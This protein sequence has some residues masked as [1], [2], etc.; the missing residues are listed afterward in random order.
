MVNPHANTSNKE[1]DFNLFVDDD[2][3]AYHI[4]LKTWPCW[5]QPP[6]RPVPPQWAA[7]CSGLT[8]QKL[9]FDFLTAVGPPIFLNISATGATTALEAPIM[10]KAHGWY[11]ATAGTLS[12]AAGGGTDVFALRSRQPMGKYLPA[13]RA[14]PNNGCIA[15]K[16]DSR[17]QGSATFS[18]DGDLIWLGNQWLTSQAPRQERNYDLLRFAKLNISAADGLIE[19]FHWR[20]NIS[21]VV[22]AHV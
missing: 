9:S 21:V 19:P 15:Q 20:Q 11:Y 8:I 1:H 5:N 10:F 4:S 13:S 14:E 6:R 22:S 2:G 18:V 3:T 7:W 16:S 12:C 17:A